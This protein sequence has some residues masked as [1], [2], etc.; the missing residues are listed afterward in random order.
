[1]ALFA[2]ETH[3]N[4]TAGVLVDWNDID[5]VNK[6][7]K[8]MKK[9]YKKRIKGKNIKNNRINTFAVSSVA[10]QKDIGSE[11]R[12]L[13]EDELRK[14]FG[15]YSAQMLGTSQKS[16]K[17]DDDTIYNEVFKYYS[18]DELLNNL[19]KQTDLSINKV[20]LKI[21]HLISSA[22]V[23]IWDLHHNDSSRIVLTDRILQI[24]NGDKNKGF[25]I[26]SMIDEL[27][28]TN[29]GLD[30]LPFSD[31]LIHNMQMLCFDLH[32]FINR[33]LTNEDIDMHMLPLM[34]NF[35]GSLS[36]MQETLKMLRRQV[37]RVND[38]LGSTVSELSNV[39]SDDLEHWLNTEISDLAKYSDTEDRIDLLEKTVVD[40]KNTLRALIIKTEAL[41]CRDCPTEIDTLQELF[42]RVIEI[43]SEVSALDLWVH[44]FEDIPSFTTM[45]DGIAF[46]RVENEEYFAQSSDAILETSKLFKMYNRGESSVYVLRGIDMNVKKG[47]FVVI[48]G[49]SGSG[50][51]TLLN[52]LS[53]LD[54]A[55]R[56]AVFFNGD[57]ILDMSDRKRTKI[58]RDHYSFIFQSYALIPHL[59]AYENVKLPLELSGLSKKLKEG[60]LDLLSDVGIG[61]YA[62]H[63]PAL[64]SGGQMQRLGIAR[65]LIAKPDVIFADEPTG[66]LDEVTGEKIMQ[67][68]KMYHEETGITIVLVTHNKD[69]IKYGDRDIYVKDGQIS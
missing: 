10:F 14:K 11:E 5:R 57:N 35:M 45:D 47:E 28:I 15:D 25:E 48:H 27:I 39:V 2:S 52:L 69:F 34:R 8:N 55:D 68:L 12:K 63:K 62:T 4:F 20:E 44:R 54:G 38:I 7:Q 6:L 49:P 13:L 41:D 65:A 1:M 22:F 30:F 67:L 33:Q 51:T 46:E 16:G 60:I 37:F 23:G 58:R 36:G 53:G 3:G 43:K 24:P 26:S 66:D 59:N 64:L 50:K 31:K 18:M 56:G 40:L 32:A 42:R 17:K 9:A 61:E 29:F 21:E 19:K